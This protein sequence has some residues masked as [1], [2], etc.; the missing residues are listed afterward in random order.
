MKPCLVCGHETGNRAASLY[1]HLRDWFD[2]WILKLKN[3]PLNYMLGFLILMT[4]MCE[5]ATI[6]IVGFFGECL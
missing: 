5:I 2:F 6:L 1:H 3:D 4:V